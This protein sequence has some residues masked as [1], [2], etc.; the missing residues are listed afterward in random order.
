M[1]MFRPTEPTD[2]KADYLMPSEIL[3]TI[4]AHSMLKLSPKR[5][6]DAMSNLKYEKI[7]K[8]INGNPRQV[9]PVIQISQTEQDDIKRDMK[10]Q[11][12]VQY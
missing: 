7:C 12:E 11:K 10:N 1:K 2:P 8:R 9:Y 3:S 4:N 6:S 5:L